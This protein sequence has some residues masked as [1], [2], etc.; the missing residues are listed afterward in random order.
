MLETN[1][2]K[3]EWHSVDYAGT[4]S[5]QDG[6]FYEDRDILRYNL[7]EDNHVTE[8]EAKANAVLI[9]SA[10]DMFNA[11]KDLYD[12][13]EVWSDLFEPQQEFICRVLNKAT[14]SDFFQH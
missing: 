3:G 10:P 11:L 7:L 14:G 8:K 13:K 2:T 6:P 1:F 4:L 12:D 5:I 9:C